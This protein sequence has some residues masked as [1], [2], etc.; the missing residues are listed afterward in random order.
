MQSSA[1]KNIRVERKGAHHDAKGQSDASATAKKCIPLQRFAPERNGQQTEAEHGESVPVGRG[2][3][4]ERKKEIESEDRQAEPKKE[5]HLE[6][7]IRAAT[8]RDDGPCQCQK[9]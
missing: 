3:F 2:R 9:Q 7:L 4:V 5:E 8:S 1:T 6:L